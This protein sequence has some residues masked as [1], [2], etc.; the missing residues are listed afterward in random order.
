MNGSGSWH[1]RTEMSHPCLFPAAGFDKKF[2][3][4]IIKIQEVVSVVAPRFYSA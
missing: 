2:L 4:H 3:C 1:R